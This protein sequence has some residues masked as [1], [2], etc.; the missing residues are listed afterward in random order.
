MDFSLEI[1]QNEW[2]KIKKNNKIA[3]TWKSQ[4]AII[5]DMKNTSE[6]ECY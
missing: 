2:S 4:N 5:L 6:K 1:L 3:S